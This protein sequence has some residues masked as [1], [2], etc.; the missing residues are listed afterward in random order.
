M[1][2]S[3]RNKDLKRRVVLPTIV[4][5]LALVLLCFTVMNLVFAA[6]AYRKGVDT[7]NSNSATSIPVFLSPSYGAWY[8]PATVNVTLVAGET[9]PFDTLETASGIVNDGAGIFTLPFTG[10]YMAEYMSV[11][12][13][14]TYSFDLILNPGTD[15][16]LITGSEFDAESQFSAQGTNPL[17]V[18]FAATAGDTVVLRY[19]NS[20]P[21]GH[22]FFT[23]DT[24]DGD[25]IVSGPNPNLQP[26]AYIMFQQLTT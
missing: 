20:V 21:A 2:E 11:S 18:T 24:P 23:P 3:T 5:T 14:F 9:M 13:C 7:F 1:S 10:V 26:V 6:I 15:D 22:A 16:T 12:C 25:S 19:I 17:T 8:I 4:I